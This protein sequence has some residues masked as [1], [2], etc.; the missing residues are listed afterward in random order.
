V[1]L[2]LN[3][4]RRPSTAPELVGLV[5]AIF[6]ANPA[7][8]S[9]YLEWKSTLDLTTKE[10]HVHLARAILAFANRMPPQAAK[11]F[12]GYGLIVVGVEP[13][14]LHGVPAIPDPVDLHH[15]VSPYTGDVEGPSWRP[16]PVTVDGKP[17]LVVEVDPP[18]W[19]DP[20]YVARRTSDK[21]TDGV[22][23]VRV[24]TANRPATSADMANLQNRLLRRESLLDV[25]VRAQAGSTV[26][27][28][29][30]GA[31]SREEWL[32]AERVRLLA[33]M[34]DADVPQPIAAPMTFDATRRDRRSL[35]IPDYQKL[36]TRATA[37]DQ[38]SADEQAALDY[39]R[40]RWLEA[41]QVMRGGLSRLFSTAPENRSR[42]EYQRQVDDYI[43][44]CREQLP[45]VLAGRAARLLTRVSLELANNTSR[46]FAA[47]EVT[48]RL[49]AGVTAEE[50]IDW[51]LTSEERLPHPPR[52]WGP[53]PINLAGGLADRP[54][55][56]G[57][58]QEQVGPPVRRVRPKF[59]RDDGTLMY[60]AV[61][62]RP[63]STISLHDIVILAEAGE[64]DVV[65]AEW[66][67]TSTATNGVSRGSVIV[68]T[69]GAPLTLESVL[70]V[71]DTEDM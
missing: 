42:D 43:R 66:S 11:T 53:R 40:R 57:L 71:E 58:L 50:P 47:V 41:G 55:A 3:V 26:T 34:R 21:I 56:L 68:P 35:T 16:T 38:L 31:S 65:A 69:G 39:T 36:L 15:W 49:P 61:D 44:S 7:D 33:A 32:A 45:R 54:T 29:V 8:E 24:G 10:A 62:L 59:S 51:P 28:V 52:L 14:I 22:L 25:D 6:A 37:G 9:D 48:V 2:K 27:P 4:Q 67:A 18:Q 60:P 70:A 19:G 5:R 13:G 30:F 20:M 64:S 12:G 23:Y 17:I 1:A 63:E 46:N